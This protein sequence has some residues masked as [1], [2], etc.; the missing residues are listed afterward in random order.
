MKQ[1]REASTPSSDEELP[2]PPVGG[3]LACGPSSADHLVLA[4]THQETGWIEEIK[5]Y[6]KG[7][8]L[9]EEDAEAERISR[10]AKS[11]CLYGEDQYRKR[12][13]GV[14][15]K[16]VPPEEGRQLIRDIHSG[17]CGHYSSSRTLAGKV[18]RSGF[19]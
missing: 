3:A 12:P 5:E 2:P 7:R 15:L 17:E 18:F 13:N 14:A 19:Y 11:Y 6:L 1:P 8:Y 9:P 16:C 4:L 10:R